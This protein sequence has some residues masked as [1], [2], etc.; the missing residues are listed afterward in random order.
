MNNTEINTKEIRQMR[1]YFLIILFVGLVFISIIYAGSQFI[2]L[3]DKISVSG[4]KELT[5]NEVIKISG[6]NKGMNIFTVNI[7]RT[8]NK[9]REEPFIRYAYVSRTFPNKISINILERE[10]IALIAMDK[11]YSFDINGILLPKPTRSNNDLPRLTGIES[12]YKFEFGKP[13]VHYQVRQGVNIIAQI[14][15]YYSEVNDFISELHWNKRYKEWIIVS[16]KYKPLIKLGTD[17]FPIKL[18]ALNNFFKLMKK[19]NSNIN[20]FKYID[21]RFKNQ[22]IVK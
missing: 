2:F 14:D 16:Y 22:L 13:T 18:Q 10:P 4:N 19:K 20:K 11:L 5:K 12:V 21:L 15:H 3:I 9:L 17:D 6:I 1:K 8:I 7:G